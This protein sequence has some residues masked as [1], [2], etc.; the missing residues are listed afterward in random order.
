MVDEQQ[1]QGGPDQAQDPAPKTK[2]PLFG[3]W[4]KEPLKSFERV[5]YLL[6]FGRNLRRWRE[7]KKLSRSK[8]SKQIGC[9]DVTLKFVESPEPRAIRHHLLAKCGRALGIPAPILMLDTDDLP[10]LMGHLLEIHDVENVLLALSK[11]IT[12]RRGCATVPPAL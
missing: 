9:A 11:A 5:D 6:V 10:A 4:R 3:D 2:R 8:L 12:E 7:K 1:I